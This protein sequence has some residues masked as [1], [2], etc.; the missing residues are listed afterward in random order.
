VSFEVFQVA[1]PNYRGPL[2]LLLYLVRKHEL[3]P[4]ALSLASLTN[5]FIDYLGTLKE[6]DLTPIG[7]FV[8][9]ASTLLEIKSRVALPHSEEE[10]EVIDANRED[11]VSRLLEYKQYRDAASLLEDRARE[12][13]QRFGRIADDQTQSDPSL[14][15]QPIREVELWDLVG[16]ISRLIRD[17]NS[18]RGTSIVYDETPLHVFMD[19]IHQ[20]LQLEESFALSELFAAKMHKST[21]ISTFLALLELVRHHQVSTDQGD[22]HGEVWIHRGPGFRIDENPDFSTIATSAATSAAIGPEETSI[23]E[24]HEFGAKKT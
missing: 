13:Q 1:L 3:E 5:Q 20:R 4:S 10:E 9:I 15:T 22:A 11:L 8:E 19:Q 23:L 7:E 14:A 6:I 12:A 24:T 16:A 2:D 17:A 21:M 18:T